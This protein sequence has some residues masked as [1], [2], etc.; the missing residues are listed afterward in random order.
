VLIAPYHPLRLPDKTLSLT[1]DDGPQP[2]TLEIA[3]FLHERGIRATFFVL[4]E[5][6]RER[7]QVLRSLVELGHV[8]GNHTNTHP[9]LRSLAETPNQL[10]SEVMEVHE[11]IKELVGA[12]PFLFRAPYGG[13]SKTAADL[14]NQNYE[15]KKYIGHIHWDIDGA[16]Y[17]IGKPTHRNPDN[18]IYTLGKCM[19]RYMILIRKSM[20]GVVL[21]HDESA[22]ELT[23]IIVP[24]L[25]DF[26]FV[27]LDEVIARSDANGI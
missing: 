16:D 24:K 7:S 14:L 12:G 8:I 27:A 15:L 19:A 18:G 5:K 10:I 2:N 23:R 11:L 17:E 25:K 13:W 26:K 22:L 21:M 1:Y 4:G 20:R 9:H 6:I 3:E